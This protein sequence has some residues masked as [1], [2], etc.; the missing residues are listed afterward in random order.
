MPRRRVLLSFPPMA[1]PFNRFL[2]TRLVAHA[3]GEATMA[4]DL[5]PHHLNRRG[6]AHG[7]V[8]TALLDSALGGAVIS[9]IPTEWWCATMSLHVQFV[10]GPGSGT[11]TA[12]GTVV[13]RGTS[14][15]FARGEAYDADGN[16]VATAEGTWRLW[17][18]KPGREPSLR[19]RVRLAGGGSRAV[20]KVVAVGRNYDEHVREMGGRP[21]ADPVLF[22]KP[23]EAVI[24]GPTCVLPRDR[25]AVHHEIE[26]A[27]L[28]GSSLEH[29]SE[30]EAAS[31]VSGYA[32]A[33]DLTLRDVQSDAKRAG[34]PWAAAKGFAG[35]APVGEIVDAAT[36]GDPE[37]RVLRLEV[38]GELRQEGNTS[39]MIRSVPAL[40]ALASHTF[41]LSP[42]DL[43]LT[44][45]PAGVGPL[46]PG[47]RVE[48]TIEGLPPLRLD[49]M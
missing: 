21:G 8:V 20:G 32:V 7:G 2:G 26:L 38:D 46:T 27:I 31:A 23:P 44:G 11:L 13:Q 49:L 14:V 37:N 4:I 45:T 39:Q 29:A 24:A 41:P 1:T 15:A 16:V 43:L 36:F 35:S 22:L 30:A 19:G 47:Q 42:G 9:S 48:A 28:V 3:S 10:R 5:E 34:T 40:L 6:V 17:S 33:L 18:R 12:T 25:G